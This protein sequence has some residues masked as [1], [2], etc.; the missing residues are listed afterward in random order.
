M[1]TQ[2]IF[3]K[4][5]NFQKCPD[6]WK[7]YKNQNIQNSITINVIEIDAL[8]N[9]VYVNLYKGVFK[10]CFCSKMIMESFICKPGWFT[11]LILQHEKNNPG[12]N[13]NRF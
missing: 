10:N 3:S 6:V 1:A 5:I 13:K 4:K 8:K 7:L 11:E 2:R 9:N 12:N